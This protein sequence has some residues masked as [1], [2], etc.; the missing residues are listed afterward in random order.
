[1]T[2]TAIETTI[3]QE[4]RDE[5]VVEAL[6]SGRSMRSVQRQFKVSQGQIDSALEKWWPTDIAARLRMLRSDLAQITKLTQVFVEKALTGDVPSG[7]CAVRL[8]E[9]KHELVGLNSATRIEIVGQPAEHKTDDV[10]RIHDAIMRCIEERKRVG[11][12]GHRAIEVEPDP[13]PDPSPDP[14]SSKRGVVG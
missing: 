7:L 13:D 6:T 2:E 12:N 11:A 5:Q 3:D 14:S 10:T 4:Q 1:M 8:W 9:R